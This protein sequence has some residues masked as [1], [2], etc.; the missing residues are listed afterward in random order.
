M[1]GWEGGGRWEG[2]RRRGR[3][4]GGEEGTCGRPSHARWK[5]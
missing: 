1:V 3:K 4:S 2:R 5:K